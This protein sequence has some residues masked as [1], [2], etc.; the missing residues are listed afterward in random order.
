LPT[1][2]QNRKA[3]VS[4][5]PT[6]RPPARKSGAESRGRLAQTLKSDRLRQPADVLESFFEVDPGSPLRVG[7]RVDVYIELAQRQNVLVIP[8]RAV[9]SSKASPRCESMLLPAYCPAKSSWAHRTAS[10]SK[11]P[12]A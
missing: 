1:G 7:L 11:S 2:R 6:F 9:S 10:T 12:K 5:Y 3:K 4:N 8:L